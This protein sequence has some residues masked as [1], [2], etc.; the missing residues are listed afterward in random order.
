MSEDS[1]SRVNGTLVWYWA[2]C[3]RQVWLMARQITPS[4]DD[5]NLRIGRT[6]HEEAYGR[7]RKEVRVENLALDLMRTPEGDVV[8]GEVKKSSRYAESA[9]LQLTYYLYRLQKLGVTA[10]GRLHFPLERRTEE[11]VLDEA[12]AERMAE[13]EKEIAALVAKED[14]V[15]AVWCKWCRKCAYRELC[16]A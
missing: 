15:P 10:K 2:I 14:P 12:A 8:V 16:W 7:D 3:K 11:V 5:D 1:L 4:H 6:L 13:V 9:R